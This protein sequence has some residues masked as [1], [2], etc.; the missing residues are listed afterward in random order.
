MTLFPD[1]LLGLNHYYP[2]GSLDVNTF[3]KAVGQSRRTSE[4]LAQQHYVGEE[5]RKGGT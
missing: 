2:P 5:W 1:N 4:P 3:M